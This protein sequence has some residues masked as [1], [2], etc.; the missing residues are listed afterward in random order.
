M[1]SADLAL[2]ALLSVRRGDTIDVR[3]AAR[4]HA[5]FHAPAMF[6]VTE[7]EA[8]MI[9]TVFEQRGEFSAAI[10]LRRMFPGIRDTAQARECVR[11][12]AGWQPLADRQRRLRH[13]LRRLIAPADD[14]RII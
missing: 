3:R 6:A 4:R 13:R 10:E 5:C 14:V 1:A 2:L 8:A 9:R 7:E 11:I 12:I